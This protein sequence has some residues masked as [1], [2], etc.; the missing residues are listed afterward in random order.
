[1]DAIAARV[2]AL[3]LDLLKSCR[4]VTTFR[5]ASIGAGRKAIT[6]RPCFRASNRTLTHGEV[7]PQVSA[8]MDAL[9]SSLGATFRT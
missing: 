3:D 5:S 6:L 9:R 8:V 2:S 4:F 1:L 7:D